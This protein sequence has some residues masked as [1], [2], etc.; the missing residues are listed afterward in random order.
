MLESWANCNGE[1]L[2]ALYS[3]ADA[4]HSW[5]G[6]DFAIEMDGTT[7]AMDATEVIWEFFEDHPKTSLAPIQQPVSS[8]DVETAYPTPGNYFDVIESGGYDRTFKLHIPSSY[9]HGTPMPLV[10]VFHGRGSNAFDAEVYLQL[11]PMANQNGFIVV[12]P[13]ATG[14]PSTWEDLPEGESESDVDDVQFIADL[15]DYLE[16]QLS[17]DPRRIYATGISNGGGMAN[18]LGCN[19]SNR[20]AAIAPVAGTYYYWEICQPSQPVAVIAFHGLR[21]EIVPYQG[22]EHEEYVNLPEIPRWA[23]AWAAL[24]GCT[25]EAVN[26]S[27]GGVIITDTWSECAGESQ[28][29]LY[30]LPLDGHN[31]PTTTFG[32]GGFEPAITANDLIWEFFVAHPMPE[33]P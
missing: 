31:W 23:A 12:Y 33:A 11:N 30:T 7:Q 28:V 6:S 26:E 5:P 10:L 24:N 14:A 32:G 8:G 19:L 4:G 27:K 21:D 3:I 13:Q 15:L 2:V 9:E 1:N 20:I 29:V 25:P 22:T 16:S 18:R 17:I